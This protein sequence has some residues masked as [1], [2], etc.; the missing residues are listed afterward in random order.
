[1]GKN[2]SGSRVPF[3]YSRLKRHFLVLVMN[4]EGLVLLKG[5]VHISS[6]TSR[7]VEILCY[8]KLDNFFVNEV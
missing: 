3:L 4:L 8:S 2:V 5:H 7:L 1:M 6:L